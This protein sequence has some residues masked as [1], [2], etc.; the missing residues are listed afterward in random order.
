MWSTISRYNRAGGIS[1]G[2][3]TVPVS[4]RTFQQ[5]ALEGVGI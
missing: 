2:E 1:T 3:R 4:E 5:L